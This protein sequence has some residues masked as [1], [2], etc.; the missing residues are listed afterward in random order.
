MIFHV[1]WLRITLPQFHLRPL[2]VAMA[3][4]RLPNVPYTERPVDEPFYI[5][6]NTPALFEGRG[7]ARMT[8]LTRRLS[9]HLQGTVS[10]PQPNGY[11]SI[12]GNSNAKIRPP[13]KPRLMLMGQ[14]R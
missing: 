12:A 13:S 14:R 3:S 5:Y 11:N 1:S 8:P 2:S 7:F 6:A 4:Y 9:A 10:N